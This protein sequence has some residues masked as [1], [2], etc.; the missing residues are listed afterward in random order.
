M[1]I[2]CDANVLYDSGFEA[3][4]GSKF[5]YETQKFE[6]NHLLETALLQKDLKE[7]KYKPQ[8]G[9]KFIISERGKTRY[10]TSNTMED[11]TVNHALCD[12]VVMPSLKP[13][14]IYDNGASQKDKGV[15]FSR[16]RLE[17]HLHRYYKKY[18]TN[19]GWLLLGDFS[20][21]YANIHHDTCERILNEKIQ[22]PFV[23]DL[24]SMTLKSFE[25]DVS[26]LSDEQIEK[27]YHEKVD[28]LMNLHVD[29]ELLT[30]KKMLSKGVDIG[31][32]LSQGIGIAYP[33]MVDNYVKN[34][35][36]MEF[37]G[38]YT[39]DFYC[40]CPDKERLKQV[41]EGIYKIADAYGLIINKKKTKICKLSSFFRYLQTGYTLTETGRLVIKIN[42]KSV[43][44][45]RRKIKAYKRLLDNDRIS[46][47]TVENSFK[48]WV[49]ANWKHMSGKQLHHMNDLYTELFGK[50]IKWK[51]T[52]LNWLME[53]G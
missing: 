8:P 44:R 49:Y 33:Y 17:T 40:V 16:K 22:D 29:P 6:M 10:I 15:S 30:G 3:M 9:Q 25:L 13:Y 42:P 50:E 4:A 5:K 38:R 48:S 39:D 2:V 12:Y 47:L 31:N 23:S 1:N 7:K 45:E 18:G 21:Y 41:L 37:Y 20:G 43:T 46:Y 11:K 53:N 52:R 36:G 26:Y 34:V 14:L 35:C 28:P 24:I 27:L 51:N 19:K 32:Q